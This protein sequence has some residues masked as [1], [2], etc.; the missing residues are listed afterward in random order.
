MWSSAPPNPLVWLSVFVALSLGATLAGTRHL[1]DAPLSLARQAVAPLQ[2]G[3]SRAG[4]T[5]SNVVA[6]WQELQRLRAENAALRSTVEELTQEIIRLR[7]AELE[8][9]DLREQLRYAQAHRDYAPLPAEII[10][11]DSS[12]LLRHAIINRGSDS[13]LEDGMTVVSPAG[14]V[15]RIVSRQARTSTILLISHPA[16]SV[17]AVIQGRPGASGVV[18]G[19]PDGRL[20]MRYLPQAETVR[21]NDVVVTSGLGGAFPPNLAIGRVVQVETRDI[22]LFQQAIVEP[23]VNF[24]KLSQVLVLTGFQPAKL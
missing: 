1:L 3:A 19:L 20:M 5:I 15:G 13:R 9:R 16:S 24:R 17:N 12:A 21:V 11:F 10:G 8:N 6:G 23:F 22:D 4:H 7:A 18:Q 2:V 14:L